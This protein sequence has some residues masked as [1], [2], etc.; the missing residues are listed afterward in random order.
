MEWKYKRSPWDYRDTLKAQRGGC[1][2]CHRLPVEDIEAREVE[3]FVWD[4][5]HACCSGQV[6]CGRCVRGLIC[7]RCNYLVG[8]I[9]CNDLRPY[10]RYVSK[11]KRAMPHL[12]A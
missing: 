2:I 1:A 11:W 9:E 10:R 6:T 12:L 4:H 5:D 7:V 8:V 3:R